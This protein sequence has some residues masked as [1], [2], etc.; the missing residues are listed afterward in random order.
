MLTKNEHWQSISEP[1][2]D[3]TLYY[4]R[5]RKR[6]VLQALFQA[7]VVKWYVIKAEMF[8]DD[9]AFYVA[10]CDNTA[11]TPCVILTHC[12]EYRCC[13]WRPRGNEHLFGVTCDVNWHLLSWSRRTTLP[14]LVA[15]AQQGTGRGIVIP[16]LTYFSALTVFAQFGSGLFLSF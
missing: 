16:W 13:C 8:G 15:L 4:H 7:D 11:R 9:E 2:I 12:D 5:W 3:I 6:C 10:F 14:R 1:G